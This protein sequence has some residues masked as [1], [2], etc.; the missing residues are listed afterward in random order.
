MVMPRKPTARDEQKFM[1][2]A[3]KVMKIARVRAK[4]S[5][6]EAA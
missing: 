1:T 5:F 3:E 6:Y 2:L 4:E